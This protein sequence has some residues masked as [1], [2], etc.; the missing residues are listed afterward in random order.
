MNHRSFALGVAVSVALSLGTALWLSS[1][2]RGEQTPGV[3]KARQIVLVDQAGRARIVLGTNA[4][5]GAASVQ[6]LDAASG[7]A[8]IVIGTPDD[9]TSRIE[10]HDSNGNERAELALT[11][12]VVRLSLVDVDLKGGV[13]LGSGADKKTVLVF[14]DGQSVHRA[15]LGLN[16]D[17]DP[18]FAIYDAK[19][20]ATWTAVPASNH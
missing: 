2:A 6:V 5:S 15:T 10:L 4:Q 3:I 12:G 14:N 1:A 7:K 18:N 11:Q 16:A 13:V 20:T 8:R 19:G 17:Q 9:S